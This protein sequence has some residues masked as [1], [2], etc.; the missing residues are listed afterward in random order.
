VCFLFHLQHLSLPLM[1]KKPRGKKTSSAASQERE[2]ARSSLLF[3]CPD[4]LIGGALPFLGQTFFTLFPRRFIAKIL[5][6]N[7]VIAATGF[8]RH[9]IYV[10][11][12][13]E[14]AGEL[15]SMPF[16]CAALS[17]GK[18]TCCLLVQCEN[19][20]AVNAAFELRQTH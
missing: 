8:Y 16:H 14:A 1:I 7:Q 13:P 12:S 4:R 2:A 19:K 5:E 9:K 6:C 17:K 10:R 15:D 11:V 18:S 20:E 3:C